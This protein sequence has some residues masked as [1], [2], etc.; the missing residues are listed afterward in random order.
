ML[1]L[2]FQLMRYKAGDKDT[3]FIYKLQF[4]IDNLPFLAHAL[5]PAVM[6]SEVETSQASIVRFLDFASLRSE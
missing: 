3:T 4:T 6:S 2:L 1:Y 5:A